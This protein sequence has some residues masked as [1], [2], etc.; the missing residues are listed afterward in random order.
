[1]TAGVEPVRAIHFKRSS[2]FLPLGNVLPMAGCRATPKS[3]PAALRRLRT[4]VTEGRGPE[5]RWR[6]EYRRQRRAA[7]PRDLICRD[8]GD[9]SATVSCRLRRA[10][11]HTGLAGIPASIITERTQ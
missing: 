7:V 2:A 3:A 4:C 11:G 9:R 6:A 10:G 5:R 1:M 8:G